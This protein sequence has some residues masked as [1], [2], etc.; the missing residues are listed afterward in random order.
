MLVDEADVI[1][2]VDPVAMARIGSS[3]MWLGSRTA[4]PGG[5]RRRPRRW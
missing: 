4:P 1:C 5:V 2:D 3:S